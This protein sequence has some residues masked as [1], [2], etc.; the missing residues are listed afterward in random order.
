MKFIE[1]RE[2]ILHGTPKPW[3]ITEYLTIINKARNS[4]KILK[5]ASFDLMIL[6][7]IAIRII[8]LKSD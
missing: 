7:F 3:E 6:K 4:V 5:K 2:K 8:F 1:L